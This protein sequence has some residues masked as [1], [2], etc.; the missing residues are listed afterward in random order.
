MTRE[1][2]FVDSAEE[3]IAYLIARLG[4]QGSW[5]VR[6]QS[7]A[8][9]DGGESVERA[10]LSTPCGDIELEFRDATPA[11]I[12]FT[13]EFVETDRTGVLDAV[14]EQAS[15]FAAENPPH[16]PG[17]LPRFPVP[18]EHYQGAVGV[19]MPIL[20]VDDLGRRGLFSPPR[21]AVL[22]WDTHEPVG[23]REFPDFD[24]ENWPPRRLGDWPAPQTA[25]ITPEQLEATIKRFS[26]CWS[27]VIDAWFAGQ[28][29]VDVEPA[30]HADMQEALS[31]RRVLDPESMEPVYRRM[32]TRFA[33]W[34]DRVA[35]SD[36]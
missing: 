27:R 21:M 11:R 14:M 19:P 33:E 6:D 22:M 17:S 16:H 15:T 34:L 4:P 7:V 3:Q 28:E 25:R 5:S 10:S 18:I 13:E 9:R 36:Q 31:L 26:A 35:A 32:N 12:S 20:A 2:V 23:V 1:I 24:P 8:T 29:D 30:L